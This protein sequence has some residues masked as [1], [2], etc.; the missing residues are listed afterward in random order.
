MGRNA[1]HLSPIHLTEYQRA[2]IGRSKTPILLVAGDNQDTLHAQQTIS[3]SP[4][5]RDS[6]RL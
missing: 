6:L 5:W 1:T 3:E 4:K 2:Y